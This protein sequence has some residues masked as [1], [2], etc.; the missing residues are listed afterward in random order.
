M[1]SAAVITIESIVDDFMIEMNTFSDSDRLRHTRF[2]ERCIT[3]LNMFVLGGANTKVV[4]VNTQLNVAYLP[5]DCIRII[6]V[7]VIL[8]NGRIYTM[9]LDEQLALKEETF[10]CDSENI[11]PTAT[12]GIP[13]VTDRYGLTSKYQIRGGRS[14]LGFYRLN[15]SLRRLEFNPQME[16][17]EVVIEYVSSGL[18]IDGQTYVPAKVR[19][20]VIAYIKFK[21]KN[22]TNSTYNERA[23]LEQAYYMEVKR[24]NDI[25]RPTFDEILDVLMNTHSPLIR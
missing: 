9:T 20:V 22:Q 4:P 2:A 16:M 23:E 10:N 8:S 11:P 19:E 17:S 7:G 24:L 5:E 25:E 14:E 12:A 18:S 3:N 15:E 6:R 13:N 21:D 1:D